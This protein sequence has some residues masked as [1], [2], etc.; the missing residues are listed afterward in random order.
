MNHLSQL[1]ESWPKEAE[2]DLALLGQLTTV[3]ALLAAAA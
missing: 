2:D 1:M 3:P